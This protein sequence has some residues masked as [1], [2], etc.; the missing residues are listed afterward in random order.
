FY[1]GSKEF[2]TELMTVLKDHHISV[3]VDEI[4][5]FSRT[6]QLF[7]F[8]HYG[9]EEFVDIVT[10]GKLAQVCATLFR[11]DHR[12]KTG[13]LSQTFTSSTAAIRASQVVLNE[14]SN[15]N[16]FGPDGKNVEIHQYFVKKLQEIADCLPNA[17]YGPFGVGA[18]IAFTP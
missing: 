14:L 2:F 8:Q 7:A 16:Y 4:Q 13:L 12:P 11:K 1:E 17:I 18:M 15:G 5:T 9:L 10:L 6:P 3:L